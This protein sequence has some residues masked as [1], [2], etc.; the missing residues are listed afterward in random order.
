MSNLLYT[1]EDDW[2]DLGLERTN[3]NTTGNGSIDDHTNYEDIS[4]P[5]PSDKAKTPRRSLPAT[6]REA[7]SPEVPL[8]QDSKSSPKTPEP[9]TPGSALNH[10]SEPDF[11]VEFVKSASR[12][13]GGYGEGIPV[14]NR[15]TSAPVMP[16]GSPARAPSEEKEPPAV[17]RKSSELSMSMKS[18]LEAFTGDFRDC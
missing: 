8:Y 13:P 17:R 12:T 11:G 14:L 4:K 5:Q 9:T 6:I 16:Y 18:R 1:P 2:S 3:N 7:I 15:K 10:G